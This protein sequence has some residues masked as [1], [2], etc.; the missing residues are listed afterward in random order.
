MSFK[1]STSLRRMDHSSNRRQMTSTW[2]NFGVVCHQGFGHL[3][4][5]AC[6]KVSIF[7]CLKD[8]DP[9]FLIERQWVDAIRVAWFEIPANS[10]NH[11]DSFLMRRSCVLILE[12]CL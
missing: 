5:D 11:P 6:F 3:N 4:S 2:V 12:A 8:E 7:G 10:Y 1:T 9:I